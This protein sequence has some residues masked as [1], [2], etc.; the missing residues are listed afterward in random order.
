MGGSTLVLYGT[1]NL[2][3]RS[4]AYD[5]LAIAAKEHWGF[6]S[7]P[8]LVRSP[9]GKPAFASFPGREFNL[10]HSGTL[11]LCALDG[12]PVG[13]DIQTVKSWRPSLPHRVC[14]QAEV[15]W[16]D[17]QTDFWRSFTALWALKESRVKQSGLGLREAISAI[18]VPLPRHGQGLYAHEG[19]W[20][21]L[22]FGPGWVGAVCAL[23][24]PPARIRWR[25]LPPT[26][27]PSR[28]EAADHAF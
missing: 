11:A 28:K 4:Q 8:T 14:S 27:S 24:I 18:S 15:D 21:R 25:P 2:E 26:L 6:S 22:Y 9:T 17:S 16:L 3:Q 19:L 23:S 13:V 5:L 10:S 7:L 1:D 20:F 12:S